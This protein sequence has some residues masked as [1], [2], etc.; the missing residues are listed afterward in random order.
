MTCPTC[1]RQTIALF[2]STACDHCDYGPAREKLHRGYIVYGP[3]ATTEEY[4]LRT[5]ADAERWRQASGR[6]CC[7]V[8]EV[9]S[10]TP[11]QWHVSR[12][13]LE[14]V[15]ADAMFEVFKD[16]RYEPVGHRAFLASEGG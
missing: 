6:L 10:L 4:V 9:Y 16:H 8:R 11:F 1:K 7:E 3:S 15:L 5:R 2:L 13:T 14:V 12:G